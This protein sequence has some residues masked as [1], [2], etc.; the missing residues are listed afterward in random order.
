MLSKYAVLS[1]LP[2]AEGKATDGLVVRARPNTPISEL[3]RTTN[4]LVLNSGLLTKKEDLS[5]DQF[6]EL[7]QTVT[8]SYDTPTLHDTT[9]DGYV[10]DLS[11]LIAGH[12]KFARNVVKPVVVAFAE[13][14]NE[15]LNNMSGLNTAEAK[16]S[17]NVVDLPQVLED[18]VFAESI[19]KYGEVRNPNSLQ[20]NA[21]LP[22]KEFTRDEILELIMTGD[23]DVDKGILEWYSNAYADGADLNFLA[24]PA[25]FIQALAPGFDFAA[26]VNKTLLAFLLANAVHNK[27]TG[28]SDEGQLSTTV[29]YNI[30]ADYRNYAGTMLTKLIEQFGQYVATNVLVLEITRASNSL[31]VCGPVY[32]TW[33]ESGGQT[34]YLY[35]MLSMNADYR[36]TD[37]LTAAIPTL[38]AEWDSYSMFYTASQEN[39]RLS[40]AKNLIK[41]IFD[42][43]MNNLNDDEKAF[44][45]GHPNFREVTSKCLE[46][47]SADLSK[48]DLEDIYDLALRVVCRCRFYYTDAEFILSEI[49]NNCKANP[50]MSVEEAALV[51]TISYITDHICDQLIVTNQI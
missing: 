39:Q 8:F 11:Q 34:E 31:T 27:E 2:L 6:A 22:I 3:D 16:Y 32:R 43:L 13:K 36:T 30:V 21:R 1:A 35:A 28:L 14:L 18:V 5:I 23:A 40:A 46:K 29:K 20:P 12:I 49:N 45:E 47:M 17:I 9:M 25:S 48:S 15:S 4:S 19:K 51:A 33:L 44:A 50:D 37:K 41:V 38:K 42:E 24:S 26:R 7:L 10:T